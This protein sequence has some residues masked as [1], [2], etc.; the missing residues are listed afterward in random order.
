MDAETPTLPACI[1]I[2][3]ASFFLHFAWEMWQ[4][5]FYQGMSATPHKEVVWLCTRATLGDVVIAVAALVPPMVVFRNGLGRLFAF[6]VGPLLA[7][8]ATGLVITV[9]LEYHAT[10]LTSRWQY[11][12]LMP[13]LPVLGTGLLPLL[14]WL[15][16]PVVALFFA[17][18]FAR[19]WSRCMNT[20]PCD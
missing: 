5:P 4:V 11:K 14:Q 18:V 20:S 1:A 16:L 3:L 9:V 17:A 13:R 19:G 2:A 7:Y 6:R 12:D 10:E 8:L 15:V